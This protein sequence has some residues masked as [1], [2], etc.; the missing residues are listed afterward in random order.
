[1]SGV[2]YVALQEA[3]QI[4]VFA[5]DDAGKLAKQGEMPVAGG[6]SVMAVGYDRR[7]LYVG[8]RDGQAEG[9]A[10]SRQEVIVLPE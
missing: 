5:I 2:L 4:A 3:N 6:P 1:M 10:G 8:Q 7:I 9:Q